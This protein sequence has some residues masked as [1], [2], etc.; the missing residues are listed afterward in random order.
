[1]P[2]ELFSFPF[3]FPSYCH[4]VVPRV[5]IIVSDGYNESSIVFLCMVF[6]SLYRCVNGVFNVGKAYPPSFLDTYSLS[7]SSQ[8]YNALFMVI[9]FL[10]HW[11]ICLSSFLVHLRKGSEYLTRGTAWVFIPLIR[12]R[13]ESFV[14]SSVVIIIIDNI[15]II[16]IIILLLW[17]FLTPA[18]T[19]GFSV[20]PESQEVFSS[21]LRELFSYVF[22]CCG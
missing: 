17:E 3:L 18:L 16:I 5:I 6:E 4:S 22:S 21:H 9:S 19:E 14:L 11:S 12:F 15:N 13:L 2:I 20:V 1:M 7:T 8:G 10:I